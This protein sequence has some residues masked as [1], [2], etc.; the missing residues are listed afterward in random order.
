MSNA[1]PMKLTTYP[2]WRVTLPDGTRREFPTMDEA[3]VFGMTSDPC[4]CTGYCVEQINDAEHERLIDEQEAL[5]S[6]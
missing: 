3:S 6:E 2:K 5:E 1:K 4:T